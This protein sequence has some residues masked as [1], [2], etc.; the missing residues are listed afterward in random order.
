MADALFGALQARMAS[1]C[2]A[3]GADVA[4]A[5]AGLELPAAA[6]AQV[7]VSVFSTLCTLNTTSVTPAGDCAGE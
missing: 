3:T 5:A 7:R 4:A 6:L 1:L 2:E